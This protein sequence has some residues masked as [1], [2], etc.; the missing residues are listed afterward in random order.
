MAKAK[1]LKCSFCERTQYDVAVLITGV[2]GNICTACTSICVSIMAD[3]LFKEAPKSLVTCSWAVTK[4]K[5]TIDEYVSH[6]PVE[7]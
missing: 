5:A 4:D 6:M 1:T 7:P 3:Y 2:T